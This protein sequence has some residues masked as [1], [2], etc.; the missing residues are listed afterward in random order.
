[1]SERFD[2]AVVGGGIVGT[3]SAL[4]LAAGYRASVLLLEAEDRLAAHQTGHN[5]G[6]IHSGLYYKPGSLKAETSTAGRE[7][8][9]RFC[10]EEGIRHERCGKLV[11]ATEER[12]L[13]ALAELARRGQANGLTGLRRLA[14]GE[15]PDYEPA[16]AGIAALWVP[17]TGIVDYPAVTQA[18]ARRFERLGGEIR[19][20]SRLRRV[21]R[22]AGGLAL[23][24]GGEVEARAVVN[25]AGLACDR[26]A[27]LC[28]VAPAV[29]IVPFR[30]DYYE[31]RPERRSLVRGLIYPVPDP[32]LPFL[33][34]H[35]TRRVGGE[36][37]AGPNAVLALAREGYSRTAFSLVDAASALTYGG[38]WRLMRRFWR[39][40]LGEVRRAFS[41][42]RFAAAL[43]RL[44]PALGADD[45]LPAG[46]G[47]RAQAVDPAGRPVDDFLFQEGPHSLHV[48][49]A[50]S[51][52]AT[53]SLAIGETVARRAAEL[54]SL[55]ARPG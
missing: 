42:R 5:S 36:V 33:G 14:A 11:V 49:N 51:P 41:R 47:I 30:G 20:G 46:C 16:A 54:F 10:S 37:E 15:I 55:P 8:L 38:T 25:C 17:E 52:G 26:V 24:A 2:V 6:V 39:S 22:R 21:R 43:A 44:V 40:G 53:A 31:L 18:M 34:V 13:P 23:E 3:A 19:L 45:I 12:E 4:A 32:A 28:G 50:P 7:A 1:M 35:L 29:R 27:R 48:L 9:Y